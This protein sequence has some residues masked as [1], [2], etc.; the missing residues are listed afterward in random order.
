MH[1]VARIPLNGEADILGALNAHVEACRRDLIAR[2][3]A[4][5]YAAGVRY[6]GKD[7]EE[8]WQIPSE[9]TSR[10]GGDCEDLASWRCAELRNAGEK[11]RVIVR[12]SR[13]GVLHAVVER[14]DGQ[15]ED[16]SRRLGMGRGR[17]SGM[18]NEPN[19]RWNIKRTSDGWEGTA[20]IPLP[21]GAAAVTAR[22]A[23]RTRGDAAARTL[24]AIEDVTKSPLIASILPPGAAPAIKAALGVARSV[25][26]LFKRKKKAARSRGT[27]VSGM[28]YNARDVAETLRRRGA[29]PA[30]VRLGAAC[31]GE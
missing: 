11:C 12:R 13:P 1:A 29:P 25:A 28:G 19:L 9:T 21:A 18:T 6:L 24:R 27:T 3:R 26:R 7:P 17:I 22:A 14:E 5:L 23:G 4:P 2:P 8:R 20:T 10:G 30:L 31:W 16:P 15:I